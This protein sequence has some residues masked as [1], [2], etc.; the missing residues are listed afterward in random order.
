MERL[1]DFASHNPLLVTAFAVLLGLFI[2]T[3]IRRARRGYREVEPAEATR[4]INDGAVVIDVREP[5]AYKAGHISGARNH[6]AGLIDGRLDDI[7]RLVKKAHGQPVLVYCDNGVTMARPASLLAH[8]ELGA[9]V[10]CL[11]GGLN[12]WRREN[13][14]LKKA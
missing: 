9:E 11:R 14:P 4:L 12:A 8:S 13:L 6:P 7:R 5:D 1:V 2:Y 3:E 10:V